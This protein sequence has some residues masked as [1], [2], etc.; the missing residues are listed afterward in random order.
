MGGAF[1]AH[2]GESQ[3]HGTFLVVPHLRHLGSPD[4]AEPDHIPG[5]TGGYLTASLA[6]H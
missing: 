1:P 2:Q 4:M 6:H 5:E 3:L